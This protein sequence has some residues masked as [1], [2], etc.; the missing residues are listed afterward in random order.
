MRLDPPRRTAGRDIDQRSAV[1]GADVTQLLPSTPLLD[2]HH[3]LN[4]E[5]EQ[6]I[7]T[8]RNMA[9]TDKVLAK[10]GLLEVARGWTEI[11]WSNEG[12]EYWR[13]GDRLFLP[14][15]AEGGEWRELLSPRRLVPASAEED[16][17]REPPLPSRPKRRRQRK[18]RPLV[19]GGL[20]TAA[21][22]AAKLNCSIKTLN[23]HVKAG[24]LK[25]VAIGHGTK[26][27]RRMFTD[28]DLDRFVVV[29]TREAPPCPSTASRVRRSGT[30]TSSGGVVAFTARP[31]SPPGGRPKR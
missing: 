30:L 10:A 18:P 3:P 7:D 21:Q 14:P 9:I 27:P 23:G 22:A 25:Y 4:H 11:S 26:R 24:G 17:W 31:K 19:T 2:R 12:I 8:A 1:E 16:E 5:V 29:Q 28:A 6:E 15:L 13:R 20:L